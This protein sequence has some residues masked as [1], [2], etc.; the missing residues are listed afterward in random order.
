[1]WVA[2]RGSA[3]SGGGGGQVQDLLMTKDHDR[4]NISQKVRSPLN[5]GLRY[6]CTGAR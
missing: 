1:M 4:H 3:C 2:G 5:S 6:V